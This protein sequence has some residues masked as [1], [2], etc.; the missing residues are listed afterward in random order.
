MRSLA[1]AR[2]TSYAF[3]QEIILAW[4]I[5]FLATCATPFIIGVGPQVIIDERISVNKFWHDRCRETF[6]TY[7]TIISRHVHFNRRILNRSAQKVSLSLLKPRITC[8][9]SPSFK[10]DAIHPAL[11]QCQHHRQREAILLDVTNGSPLEVLN[12]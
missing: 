10:W 11:V 6:R 5:E 7:A 12:N 8:A 2:T 3:F 1:T 4:Y 9:S